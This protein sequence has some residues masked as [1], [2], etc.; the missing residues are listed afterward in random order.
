MSKPD[1]VTVAKYK[2]E[3]AND[4]Q[5]ADDED[6]IVHSD[7]GDLGSEPLERTP[8]SNKK[9]HIPHSGSRSSKK[10]TPKRTGGGFNKPYQLSDTLAEVCGG[11]RVLSRP[12]VVKMLWKYIK[13]HGLQNPSDKR[14]ILCDE[15]LKTI[16]SNKKKVTAFNMN[17]VMLREAVV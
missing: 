8:I 16:F 4:P 10:N 6:D 13:K 15:A 11:L 17:K 7:D 14:E 5:Q 1:E 12:K 9:R 3:H 2:T